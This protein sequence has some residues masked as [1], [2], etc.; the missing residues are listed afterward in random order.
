MK[1][2][3]AKFLNKFFEF[4]DFFRLRYSLEAK[5]PKKKKKN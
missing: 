1:G 5:V 4:E 2:R 3:R